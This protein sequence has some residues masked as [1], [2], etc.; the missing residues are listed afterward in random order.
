MTQTTFTH[1]GAAVLARVAAFKS[2]VSHAFWAFKAL[3]LN[4]LRI[5]AILAAKGLNLLK[6]HAFS[7]L[8]ALKMPKMQFKRAG[9]FSLSLSLSLS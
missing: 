6:I 7:A 2:L 5:H 9:N 3:K 4:S 1:A 8:Q